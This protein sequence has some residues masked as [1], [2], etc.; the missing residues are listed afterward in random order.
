MYEVLVKMRGRRGFRFQEKRTGL[1]LRST[2]TSFNP[3]TACIFRIRIEEKAHAR[4]KVANGNS[5]LALRMAL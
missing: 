4:R 2:S 5:W 3:I 1:R